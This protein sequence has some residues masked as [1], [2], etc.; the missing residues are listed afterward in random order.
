[1]RVTV[2]CIDGAPS[3]EGAVNMTRDGAATF[4]APEA[5]ELLAAQLAQDIERMQAEIAAFAPADDDEKLRMVFLYLRGT[6]GVYYIFGQE[7][8]A[9]D[10]IS[11]LGGVDVATELGWSD[12]QPLTDE[13]MVAADPDL[14][15][16]MSGGIESTAG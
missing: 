2:V 5:G 8:G 7:S 16:V 14:I 3:V 13:A 12:M 10:L 11:G 4:G 1:A 6:S 9:S 15:L